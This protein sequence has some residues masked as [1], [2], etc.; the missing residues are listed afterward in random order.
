MIAGWVNKIFDAKDKS[1]GDKATGSGAKEWGCVPNMW[2]RNRYDRN[3]K[4]RSDRPEDR[5]MQ[6]WVA[7]PEVINW[8]KHCVKAAF[9]QSTGRLKKEF[10]CNAKDAAI[11]ADVMKAF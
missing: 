3:G 4:P 1:T 10:T 2:F 11:F 5:V 7:K 8:A 6:H 9:D